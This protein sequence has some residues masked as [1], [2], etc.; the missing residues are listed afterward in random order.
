VCLLGLGA[1]LACQEPT[2]DTV[3]VLKDGTPDVIVVYA[4][5]AGEGVKAA[6]TET[7][8]SLRDITGKSFADPKAL[9]A[10]S[11]TTDIKE[12]VILLIGRG[13][14]QEEPLTDDDLQDLGN[15]GY[16]MKGK[17]IA[18]K[19]VYQI[20]GQSET[21][22]QYGTYALLRSWGVRYFHPSET[23]TPKA[24]NLTIDFA[25]AQ[26]DKPKMALRG[27]HHHTQHPIPMS[28]YMLEPDDKHIA[29]VKE[30]I[31]WLTRNRQNLFQCHFLKTIDMTKWIPYAKQIKAIASAYGVKLGMTLS[32]ADQQQNNYRLVDSLSMEKD[33]QTKAIQDRLDAFIEAGIEVFVFQ[34]GTSEFT[35][36]KDQV[37]LDWLNTAA[38]HLKAKKLPAFAWIHTA[39]EVKADDGK[40]Y[41][42]H[43]PEKADAAMGTYVHTTMFYDMKH[44]APVYSNENFNHQADFLNRV[45]GKRQVVYFPETAWWLGFDNNLP[46][47][48]P[49]TGHS[50]AVDILD[51]LKGK[52]I[53]G[54][55]TFTSGMEWGYWKYDHFL[56][57]ITWDRSTTWEAYI[58]DFTKIFGGDA[59][60]IQDVMTQ[61]TNY[62]VR[63]FYTDNPL[64]FFYIA[65]ELPQDELGQQVGVLARRP[66]RSFIEIFNL[67]EADYDKWQ[68]EDFA[69]LTKMKSDYEALFAKLPKTLKDD[70]NAVASKLYDEL[71][72]TLQ[73]YVWRVQHTVL[74]YDAVQKIREGRQDGGP[75]GKSDETARENARKAADDLITKA[76]AITQNVLKEIK[77]FENEMYRYP[78]ELL[79]TKRDSLT[80]YKF[81][82]LWETSTAFFWTRRDAQAR[83]LAKRAAGQ[84]KEE[85]PK[86]A[87][88]A[89]Y[90]AAA[91]QIE[92]V[93]PDSPLIKQVLVS[94]IPGIFA[95]PGRTEIPDGKVSA[96]WKIALDGNKNKQPDNDSIGTIDNGTIKTDNG[97]LVFTGEIKLYPLPVIDKAGNDLG[98]L[99]L[100][101]VEIRY[102]IER[103]G[104]TL[105]NIKKGTLKARVVLD[106]L[107]NVATQ[108][109]GIDREGL[110]QILGSILKFDPKNPPPNFS[111]TIGFKSFEKQ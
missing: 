73:I 34:F 17:Q 108:V 89:I 62:Q 99:G 97:A 91:D 86:P 94:F 67:K 36:V 57:R 53:H 13:V 104:T 65:G 11:S 63:D 16:A 7:V 19:S 106:N 25:N 40:S 24:D 75:G 74:L 9:A 14:L 87:P 102:E 103:D 38:A 85:W 79:S 44:P 59:T 5:D 95:A 96:A 110:L 68:K 21:A 111:I 4:S 84:L 3:T 90:L 27:F 66:K 35:K 41:F 100:N 2:P 80:S 60:S 45:L 88:P 76:E 77:R 22:H 8:R 42:Y 39:G 6:A 92:I 107:I 50:R 48:L 70:S 30:Y 33:A 20:A 56:T 32:F 61:W 1:A 28:V 69:K 47:A 109:D 55:V 58:K 12:G 54:H 37:A 49:I 10:G 26:S 18:G 29:R 51:V 82:Y 43:L 93:E 71:R 105:K 31:V 46:L 83:S 72:T 81:G 78:N 101:D 15:E 98:V 64:H 52:D 23:Y